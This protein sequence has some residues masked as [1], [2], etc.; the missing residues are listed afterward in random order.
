MKPRRPT[1]SWMSSEADVRLAQLGPGLT[2]AILVRAVEHGQD[3]ATEFSSNDPPVSKGITVWG[4]VHRSLRDDVVPFGWSRK[5]KRGF[6]SVLSPD[7]LMEVV[8]GAGDSNTGI[9]S[10]I[11]QLRCSKGVMTIEAVGNAQRSFAH[12]DS[13]WSNHVPR[14]TWLLLYFYDDMADDLRAELSLPTSLGADGY[15]EDWEERIILSAIGHVKIGV[16]RADSD[17]LDTLDVKV[18][19]RNKASQDD[20]EREAKSV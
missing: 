11:P 7:G 6:A 4:K 2:Q 17:N 8:V 9:R 18:E 5:D 19:K 10:A 14:Q 1:T 15:V 13:A 3:Y 16:Q 20:N 12:V